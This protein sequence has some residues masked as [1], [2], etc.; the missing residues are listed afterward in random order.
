MA[1][2]CC[3]KMTSRCIGPK[4]AIETE[5]ISAGSFLKGRT[6]CCISQQF[7]NN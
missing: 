2:L 1:M 6:R 3:V 5:I 4:T 7:V